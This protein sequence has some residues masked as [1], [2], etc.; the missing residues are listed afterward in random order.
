[1]NRT[2]AKL[3]MALAAAVACAGFISASGPAA[4][5]E[6]VLTSASPVG[7]AGSAAG[8]YDYTY[9]LTFGTSGSTLLG[10][11]LNQAFVSLNLGGTAAALTA[12]PTFT[13]TNTGITG[14]FGSPA[15][16]SMDGGTYKFMYTGSKYV[17]S[18]T[19]AIGYITVMSTDSSTFNSPTL[20]FMSQAATNVTITN[21][22]GQT[23]L[24][25]K[26][27]NIPASA[28]PAGGPPSA[29]PLPAALWPTLLTLAGMAVVGGLRFRRTTL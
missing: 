23:D 5:A 27:V 2:Y 11:G 21:P 12:T 28:A 10:S 19:E 22:N 4:Q 24:V 3:G 17:S 25:Q 16:T 29:A 1:M 9:Y 6:I 26:Q 8:T 7:T 14:S 13:M 20:N 18:G 15:D